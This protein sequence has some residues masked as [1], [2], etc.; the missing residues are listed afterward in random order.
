MNRFLLNTLV[1]TLIFFISANAYANGEE[2]LTKCRTLI[3]SPDSLNNDDIIETSMGAGQCAGVI[4]GIRH[5]NQFYEIHLVDTEKKPLFCIPK[6]ASNKQLGKIIIKYIEDHP[7][8][9]HENAMN[10]V[11][12]AFNKA[13]PC[14]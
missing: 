4:S 5:L 6:K 2:F 14:H 3:D 11:V 12:I 1:I 8:Q 13:F 9:M 10:L 7:E